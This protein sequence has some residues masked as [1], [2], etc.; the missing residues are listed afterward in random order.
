[1]LHQVHDLSKIQLAQTNMPTF[2]CLSVVSKV[3]NIYFGPFLNK[4]SLTEYI[5]QVIAASLRSQKF[6]AHI[7]SFPRSTTG[8]VHV[9]RLVH[10]KSFRFVSLLCSF[11][12]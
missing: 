12:L 1:M 5:C 9:E 2:S 6:K 7:L 8:I 4:C 10:P 11:I 3:P